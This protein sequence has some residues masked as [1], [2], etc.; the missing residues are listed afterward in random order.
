MTGAPQQSGERVQGRGNRLRLPLGWFAAAVGLGLTL[1]ALAPL[2]TVVSGG[3][4]HP[5]D[6]MS[7]PVEVTGI[8]WFVGGVASLN[9]FLW[10]A[11]AALMT[12]AAAGLWRHDRALARGLAAWSALAAILLLDDRFLL[13]ELV[14]PAIVGIPELATYGFYLAIALAALAVCWRPFARLPEFGLLLV[15]LAVLSLSVALDLTGWDS[16][17]RRVAEETTK[18]VAAALLASFPAAILVRSV[19][20]GSSQPVSLAGSAGGDA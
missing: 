7:D 14:L 10:A 20:T 6:L 1:S 9:L 8:L 5:M 15:A 11:C 16:D 2:A 13:H 17:V 4:I 12:V 19:R 3:S 18:M